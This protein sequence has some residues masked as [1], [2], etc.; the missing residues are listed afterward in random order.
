MQNNDKKQA[1]TVYA[2]RCYFG[3]II[4]EKSKETNKT[5]KQKTCN[6]RYEKEYYKSF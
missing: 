1:E 4:V 5:N 3:V 6:D 2:K